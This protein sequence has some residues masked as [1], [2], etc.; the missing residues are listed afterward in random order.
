MKCHN[1][2][3]LLFSF[4]SPEYN[5]MLLYRGIRKQ[6]FP[7]SS[8]GNMD[9]PL[10]AWQPGH[11]LPDATRQIHRNHW[12][13][14]RSKRHS[15]QLQSDIDFGDQHHI[16]GNFNNTGRTKYRKILLRSNRKWG[17]VQDYPSYPILTHSVWPTLHRKWSPRWLSDVC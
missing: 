2:I 13:L 8:G 6:S 17:G 16:A 11:N 5:V 14:C 7:P 15:H 3:F 1:I 10:L 12:R 4:T 9:G